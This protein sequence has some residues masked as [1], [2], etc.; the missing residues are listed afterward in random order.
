MIIIVNDANILIDLIELQLLPNFFALAFEFH[1]TPLVFEELEKEQQYTLLTYVDSGDLIVRE[2]T[3]EQLTEINNIQKSKPALS[4]QDCSA[5]YQ[6][7]IKA[8]I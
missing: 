2:M 8:A 3:H 5:F 1:T 6:A 4:P 7:K